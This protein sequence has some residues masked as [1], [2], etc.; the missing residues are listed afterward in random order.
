MS[1]ISVVKYMCVYIDVTLFVV[2]PR[3]VLV[4]PHVRPA[5]QIQGSR[6]TVHNLCFLFTFSHWFSSSQPS[7]K[8]ASLKV[9]KGCIP[10]RGDKSSGTIGK[11]GV[12]PRNLENI[13]S[14][15]LFLA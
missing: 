6:F 10:L 9:E 4:Y 2:L 14:K 11:T 15:S 12:Q 8:V 7:C 1:L 13:L 5:G 3:Q